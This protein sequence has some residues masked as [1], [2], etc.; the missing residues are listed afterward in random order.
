MKM[1]LA[2]IQLKFRQF[3][4]HFKYKLLLVLKVITKAENIDPNNFEISKTAFPNTHNR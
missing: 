4:R 3:N 2:K 1:L